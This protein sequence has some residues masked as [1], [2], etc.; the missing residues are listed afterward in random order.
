MG[1][2]AHLRVFPAHGL[3]VSLGRLHAEA[4]LTACVRMR[5]RGIEGEVV[6]ER[7]S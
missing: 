4:R 6:S 2:Q 7:E 3:D 5:V 1:F